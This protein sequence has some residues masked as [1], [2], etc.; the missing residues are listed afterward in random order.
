MRGM[1]TTRLAIH[2]KLLNESTNPPPGPSAAEQAD[3]TRRMQL[4]LAAH[5]FSGRFHKDFNTAGGENL[6]L[7]GWRFGTTIAGV[8]SVGEWREDA[9]QEIA[10]VSLFMR[11]WNAGDD[12]QALGAVQGIEALAPFPRADFNE[13]QA[14]PR[15][16]L[17]MFYPDARW[18]ADGRVE[19]AATAL[20]M[21]IMAAPG[22]QP[23][24]GPI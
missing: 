8:W 22:G 5:P 1:S 2:S 16:C 17:V 15:P 13:I 4:L 14:K 20:A 19:L 3:W 10:G 7:Q 11:G 12:A 21:A 24:G 18:H 9:P 6:H 23:G